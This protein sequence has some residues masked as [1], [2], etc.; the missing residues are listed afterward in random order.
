[1]YWSH[2]YD[3]PLACNLVGFGKNGNIQYLKFVHKY[4]TFQH[5]HTIFFP[6]VLTLIQL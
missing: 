1:M 3:L 5:Y 6:L 4:S 2:K